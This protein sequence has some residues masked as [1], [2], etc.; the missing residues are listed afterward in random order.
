MSEVYFCA[1]NEYVPLLEKLE[2]LLERAGVHHLTGIVALKMHMGELKNKSFVKP[3]YIKK[4][5]E[6][7]K[8]HG[9]DPFVTDTTTI[10]KEARYTA[11]DYYRTAFAHGFLPSYLGCP[12]IIADGLKDDGVRVNEH[13][14]IA[15]SIYES[16]AMLLVSHA[17][18]HCASSF[19]GALKNLAMG[20]VTKKTK[21]YQH[22]VTRPVR[23][24]DLCAACDKC[25]AVCKHHA[26]G[27]DHDLILENCVSC[28][29]CIAA[30]TTGAIK[31]PEGMSENLQKRIADV[32]H[33]VL[34]NLPYSTFL[35]V[36]FLIEIT[37]FCDC[38]EFEPEYLSPDIGVLA[39]SDIV[40]IDRATIDLIGAD[41]FEGDPT[42]QVREAHNL[43][44][45]ELEYT[46]VQI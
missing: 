6:V 19:G 43:G 31:P 2:V 45:G 26:I 42:I 4:L 5:V 23:N 30:C 36:T 33:A 40:A 46:L 24:P 39:S 12:V 11:M 28:G 32:A 13:V 27:E 34:R 20:C 16:D 15:K 9:G 8:Q 22:E 41:K 10:Y 17:T 37:P 7:M 21:K 35:F 25:R 3:F 1:A 44:L 14:E 29:S 18:G 38:A